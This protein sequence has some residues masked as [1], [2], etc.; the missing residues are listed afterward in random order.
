MS[1]WFE[2]AGEILTSLKTGDLGN[3]LQSNILPAESKCLHSTFCVI[4]KHL[5]FQT[6][7]SLLGLNNSD[8]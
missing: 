3:L 2:K 4:R 8:S 7:V 6:L 5:L 1:Q